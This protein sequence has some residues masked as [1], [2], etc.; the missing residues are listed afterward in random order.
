METAIKEDHEKYLIV[1]AT[2]YAMCLETFKTIG[3]PGISQEMAEKIVLETVTMIA[4]KIASCEKTL[5]DID[6]KK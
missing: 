4:K 5:L 2:I 6:K 1:G 3:L